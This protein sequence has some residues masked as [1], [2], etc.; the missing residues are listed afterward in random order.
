MGWGKS[1]DTHA[2][3]ANCVTCMLLLVVSLAASASSTDPPSMRLAAACHAFARRGPMFN[4]V[5]KEVGAEEWASHGGALAS[6]LLPD[7]PRAAE[8]VPE[9]LDAA[10][11]A[12]VYHLYLPVFFWCRDLV[13]AHRAA[14]ADGPALAIGLSAPQGCGKTTLV[15]FLVD[16][17][18][19]EKLTCA[20]ASFDDFYLTGEAQDK[21][22]A[23]HPD[24][25]L[26]KVRGNAGSHDMRLG[27]T[28][29]R[30]LI[31]EAGVAPPQ[32][33]VPVVR[34]DKSARGG[35]GDRA[36]EAQWAQQ[37]LPVDV[38]LLEGWMAGFKPVA[39]EAAVLEKHAGLREVNRLLGAYDA[40]HDP[41]GAWVV[42][43]ADSVQHVFAWRLQAERAMAAA[44]R[45]GMSDAQVQDFVDRYMPA[46]DAYLPA[47]HA[48][49]R[50][51]GVDGK[52]T[53]L[54]HVDGARAP[55][56]D[57]QRG[58]GAGGAP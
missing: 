30:A 55:T 58:G 1:T 40:W 8:A 48:A 35:R 13:R 18:A 38:V 5:P 27:S 6:Q 10:V 4:A 46:Y 19:A 29:L 11:A 41:L 16:R 14:N 34:Y 44:G 7:D 52:P 50:G 12:R 25:P 23:D 22:S 15:D 26:L 31:G 43:A 17:F 49:A 45:P 33:S 39:A 20:A 36:A 47:L 9:E 42:V 28:T 56:E 51:G 24:N 54:V 53:L 3:H 32:R 21:L 57:P 2:A 37:S